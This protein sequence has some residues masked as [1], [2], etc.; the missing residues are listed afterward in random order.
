MG[1]IAQDMARLAEDIVR[2]K[3]ERIE[4]INEIAK[5]TVTIRVETNMMLDEFA[6]NRKAQ[7]KFDKANRVNFVTN[8]V[9]DV[10]E[11]LDVFQADHQEMAKTETAKRKQSVK[12][13]KEET[14]QKLDDFANE[15]S[16]MRD[17]WQGKKTAKKSSRPA[18]SAAKK[19]VVVEAAATRV[20]APVA[21]KISRGDLLS[22]LADE[23]GAEM[24]QRPSAAKSLGRRRRR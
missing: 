12:D 4:K 1:N 13:I 22:V 14:N 21:A 3:G 6:Q 23:F 15:M 20:F 5:K 9:S 2:L 19:E 17:A 24:K 16:E 10:S 7:A 18:V 8:L 11:M